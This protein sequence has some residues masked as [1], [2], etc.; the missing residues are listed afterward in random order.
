MNCYVMGSMLVSHH[1][2]VSYHH[3]KTLVFMHQLFETN[4]IYI[5]LL[6]LYFRMGFGT[7]NYAS[8]NSM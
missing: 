2:Y 4:I 5:Y 8:V 6:Q 7:K 3:C 1:F